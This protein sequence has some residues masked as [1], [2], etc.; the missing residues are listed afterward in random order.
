MDY[1]LIDEKYIILTY[2]SILLLKTKNEELEQ[3]EHERLANVL[4]RQYS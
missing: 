2:Y 4:I 3:V 1:I